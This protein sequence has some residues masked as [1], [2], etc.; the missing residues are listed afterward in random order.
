[1]WPEIG[2]CSIIALNL[3][4]TRAWRK[5]LE[6]RSPFIRRGPSP[7][8]MS[9]AALIEILIGVAHRVGAALAEHDLEIDR[10]QALIL[11]AMNHA[12]RA[13]DAFP[14]AEPAPQLPPALILDEHGQDALQ[15]K[16]QLLDLVG[17]RRVAL[18]RR[19]I[20]D[21]QCEGARRDH[22]GVVMLARA[23]GANKAVL[24]PPVALDLGILE[25]FPI[26][27]LV[28]K[29]ADIA[30]GDLVKAQRGDFRRHLVAGGGH[31]GPP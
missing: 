17:V 25:G 26:R 14:R 18:P 20:D 29:P 9:V 30:L 10:L 15:D 12:R 4:A 27:N 31:G 6:C 16:E 1:M 11:E 24:G 13:G 19:A 21:A 3:G 22:A 2:L 8:Q 28:A 23:A 7:S 5:R